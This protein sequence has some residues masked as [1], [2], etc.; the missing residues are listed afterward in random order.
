M[1]SGHA[2]AAEATD[3][4]R[5]QDKL[6]FAQEVERAS[7]LLNF[8]TSEAHACHVPDQIIDD[9]RASREKALQDTPPS[10]EDWARLTK[11]H[12]DLV[13]VPRT[14][15]TFDRVPPTKFWNR[16]TPWPWTLLAAVVVPLIIGA[17]VWYFGKVPFAS[18]YTPV[19]LALVVFA[20]AVWTYYVFTGVVTDAKLNQMIGLCYA[21]TIVSLLGSVLL[22]AI[23]AVFSQMSA[24]NAPVSIVQGCAAPAQVSTATGTA[25]G[26]PQ[27]VICA[28]LDGK[29]YDADTSFQWV[30]NLGGVAELSG[31]SNVPANQQLSGA[32][33]A[34]PATPRP[35]PEAPGAASPPATAPAPPL[36]TASG[37]TRGPSERFVIHG[38]VVVPLYVIILALFGSAV[39]M[40]RRVP[41]YQQRAMDTQDALT[42]VQARGYL[43]FQ[44]MQVLSASLIAITVYYIVKPDT[45]MTSV[46]LGFG[47]GFASEPILL[48]IRGLV[49]KLSP[50]PTTAASVIT[51]RVTPSSVN[52]K[53]AETQQFTAQVGG[54]SNSEVIWQIDP[55]DATGGAISQSGLYSAPKTSPSEKT[56]TITATSA[57]D[58]TKSGSAT[59][60]L[61]A[62]PPP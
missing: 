20:V 10:G 48:M 1:P 39:S 35:E 44:I 30:I 45:P 15:V 41:E 3:S 7:Q 42:N 38:G 2:N 49:E 5:T 47:S 8:L 21:F 58:R 62:D 54:S 18:L 59:I 12:R 43:V 51:V 31:A 32:P 36:Q 24:Q 55:S 40:T 22:F 28:R 14:S 19:L 16:R 56:V 57:A 37:P 11:A 26:I 9:I 50:A 33:A 60:K 46:L 27:E 4:T 61:S 25:T 34:P 13:A 29:G 52:R 53:S 17:L 6:E 23:P